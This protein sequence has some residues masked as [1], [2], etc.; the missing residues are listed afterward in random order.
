M[1]RLFFLGFSNLKIVCSPCR[2]LGIA[3]AASRRPCPPARKR[4]TS[5][6]DALSSRWRKS[7]SV[8]PP[9][10][11]KPAWLLCVCVC[12]LGLHWTLQCVQFLV[13][14]HSPAE[15]FSDNPSPRRNIIKIYIYVRFIPLT[16]VCVC[17]WVCVWLTVAT[18]VFPKCDRRH[19]VKF[20]VLANI[21]YFLST[22]QSID[23]VIKNI[24]LN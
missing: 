15:N 20:T 16:Y 18:I 22:N 14:L 9:P 24:W 3:D 10:L 13:P 17:V 4:K 6:N 8:V 7:K 21:C 2:L 5:R 11:Y 1:N 19:I 23:E 12:V